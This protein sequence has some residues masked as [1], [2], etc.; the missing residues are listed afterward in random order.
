MLGGSEFRLRQGFACA[1]RL[2]A[3][4]AAARLRSRCEILFATLFQEKHG[5]FAREKLCLSLY[6]KVWYDGG[7]LKQ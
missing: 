5:F 4:L 1:K 3:A 7:R 2:Y 6:A